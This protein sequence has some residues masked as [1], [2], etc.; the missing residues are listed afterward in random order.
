M[1]NL[2]LSYFMI[3]LGACQDRAGRNAL[4]VRP[5]KQWRDTVILGLRAALSLVGAEELPISL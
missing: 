2:V 5:A 1:V 3:G 4:P